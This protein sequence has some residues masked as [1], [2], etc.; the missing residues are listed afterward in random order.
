MFTEQQER[1]IQACADLV[2]RTGATEFEIGHTG[3]S[4]ARATWCAHAKHRGAQIQP[5]DHPTPDRAARALAERLLTGARC[6]HCQGLVT[7]LDE[8]AVALGPDRIADGSQWDG[9]ASGKACR[10]QQIGGRWAGGCR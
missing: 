6:Q 2:G 5:Q 4:S 1:D 9:T 3:Y 7:L 10:W 8:G